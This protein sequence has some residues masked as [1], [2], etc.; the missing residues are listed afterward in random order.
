MDWFINIVL[1]FY[2]DFKGAAVVT[3]RS[4]GTGET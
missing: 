4:V 1:V 3:G 2:S